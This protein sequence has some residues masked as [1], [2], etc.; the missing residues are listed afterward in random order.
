[1]KKTLF[2]IPGFMEKSTD[3]RYANLIKVF[4]E[5]CFDIIYVPIIWKHRTYTDYAKQFKEFYQKNKTGN[6]FVLGFSY[7]AVV[8]FM[9]APQIKPKKL[10]LCSISN[11]FKED[12]EDM[13]KKRNLIIKFIGKRRFLDAQNISAN[14]IAQE[15]KTPTDIFIGE[16]ELT[17]KPFKKRVYLI[18]KIIKYS[19]LIV[20]SNTDHEINSKEYT[21][22]IRKRLDKIKK[23]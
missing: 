17:D 4:K 15:I 7:G 10:F 14:K 11:I 1:M 13:N 21:I 18:H 6:D 22:S 12:L 16:K 2:I 23:S 3:S 19:N 9:I 20:V 5:K 8:A